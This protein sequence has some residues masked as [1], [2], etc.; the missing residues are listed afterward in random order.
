MVKG[1]ES[2]LLKL[3]RLSRARKKLAAK[4]RHFKIHSFIHF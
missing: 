4:V 2:E 3:F 1:S